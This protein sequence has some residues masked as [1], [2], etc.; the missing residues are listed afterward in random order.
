M[1]R[2]E[3]LA[4]EH[5]HTSSRKLHKDS[6]SE[7]TRGLVP[8]YCIHLVLLHVTSSP[9]QLS[10]MHAS[11]SSTIPG[12][13][14]PIAAVSTVMPLGAC[15]SSAWTAVVLSGSWSVTGLPP[16]AAMFS[17]WC[18]LDIIEQRREYLCPIVMFEVSTPAETLCGAAVLL[19]TRGELHLL[20][21]R[22]V[23]LLYLFEQA[24]SLPL[25]CLD[26]HLPNLDF[27]GT[28]R[29]Q[30]QVRALDVSSDSFLHL[31][32]RK[33]AGIGSSLYQKTRDTE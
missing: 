3:Q 5:L 27:A 8:I 11:T 31:K 24:S 29:L 32:I 18:A 10:W 22:Y 1:F 17:G 14:L 26:H 6:M 2:I 15:F 23:S 25:D 28:C 4:T 16:T 30:K 13:L 9:E 7:F 21:V 12:S 33:Q 20:I 19:D